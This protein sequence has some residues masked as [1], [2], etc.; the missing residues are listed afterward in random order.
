MKPRRVYP[1]VVEVPRG[2][3]A[4]PADGP[5]GVVV[6]LRP[7]VPGALVVPAELPLE[8]SRPGATATF[9]VTP[10]ARGSLP[11]AC[12]RVLCD[13]RPVQE[14]RTRMTAKTQ[15]L[16]WALLLLALVGVPL[17]THWTV[18]APLRGDVPHLRLRADHKEKEDV[19]ANPPDEHTAKP[20][21]QPPL[22]A[23]EAPPPGLPGGLVPPPPGRPGVPAPPPDDDPYETVMRPGSPGEVLA[24]RLSRQL[25]DIL[26]AFPGRDAVAGTLAAGA[27]RGYAVLCGLAPERPAFW[28]GVLLLILAFGSWVLHRP[29]RVR[30]RGAVALAAVAPAVTLRAGETAETLPLA[31]PHGEPE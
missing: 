8:V 15:R 11:Q 2:R 1:L 31:R 9:Q 10:L 28:L 27:G 23:P 4:A 17:L 29:T 26:P 5:T 12:V 13:G 3:G 25:H 16:A 20:P 19:A 24:Y 7:V 6:T 22:P 18:T 30:V 14:V 21:A